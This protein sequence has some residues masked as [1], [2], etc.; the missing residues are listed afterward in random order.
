MRMLLNRKLASRGRWLTWTVGAGFLVF[1]IK[2]LVWLAIGLGAV[3]L[4]I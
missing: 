4:A 1:F 3:V 2:G